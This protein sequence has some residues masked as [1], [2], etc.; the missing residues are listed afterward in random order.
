MPTILLAAR[1]VVAAMVWYWTPIILSVRL[2]AGHVCLLEIGSVHT[3]PFE[4]SEASREAAR[5]SLTVQQED[6][7]VK[8]LVG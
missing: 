5:P 3:R 6:I 2:T 7:D 8:V 4:P 1:V